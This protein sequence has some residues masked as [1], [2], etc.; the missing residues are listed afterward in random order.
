MGKTTF[1]IF[2]WTPYGSR[3]WMPGASFPYGIPW[4]V[5]PNGI[6]RKLFIWHPCES[7]PY[8]I[9]WKVVPN[10]IHISAKMFPKL[11]GT[12]TGDVRA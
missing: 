4:K 10:G 5:V 1:D 3:K 2:F 9:H 6:L 7:F 12:R 11:A 8:G